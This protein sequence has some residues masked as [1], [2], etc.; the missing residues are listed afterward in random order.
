LQE[1]Q[2]GTSRDLEREGC[3]IGLVRSHRRPPS[4]LQPR[5]RRP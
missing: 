4:A 2:A 3:G 1:D 5:D